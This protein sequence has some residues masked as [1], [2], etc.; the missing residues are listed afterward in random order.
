[1]NILDTRECTMKDVSDLTRKEWRH[2]VPNL[3][4]LFGPIA[5]K[6]IVVREGL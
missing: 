4:I 1:M 2:G 3:N 6:Q 5:Q